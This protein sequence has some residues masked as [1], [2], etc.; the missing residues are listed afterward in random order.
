MKAYFNPSYGGPET[1]SIQEIPMPEVREKDLL[2]RML[3]TTVNRTD[4]GFLRGE[5]WLAR[6]YAGFRKRRFPVLGNE[7]AGEIVGTGS[8]VTNF[9]KGDLVFGFDDAGFGCHAE[10]KT[11]PEN[12]PVAL[13]PVGLNLDKAVA[14]TEGAHYALCDLRAAKVKEGQ[15]VLVHGATGAIGSAA[16]QLALFFGAEVT[17]VCDTP[18]MEKIRSFGPHRLV[19]RLKEDFTR[20]PGHYDLVFDAVGKSSFR[21]CKPLLT[22]NGIYISTELGE[23]WENP[24]LGLMGLFQSGKRVLFPLPTSSR[25]DTEFLGERAQMGDLVPLIDRVYSFEEIPEAYRYVETGQKIGNVVVKI[26]D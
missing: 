19:D 10:F 5:P 6:L 4:C 20:V 25:E 12:G 21:A 14:I 13:I 17:A 16:V 9:K 11:I 2:I 7:F 1:L 23:G 24:F 26:A 22:K 15:K 3:R 18:N 8:G